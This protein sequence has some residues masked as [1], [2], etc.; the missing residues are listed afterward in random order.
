MAA[1]A[2]KPATVS[3][4]KTTSVQAGEATAMPTAE[5]APVPGAETA[6]VAAAEAP[7]VPGAGPARAGSVPAPGKPG[8]GILEASPDT[9]TIPYRW[10]F[11]V[12]EKNPS[13]YDLSEPIQFLSLLEK[14]DITLVNLTA[15]SPYYNPH[16]QRPAAFPHSD[17]YEA[18][19]DP[20]IGVARINAAMWLRQRTLRLA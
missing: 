17:G 10:G 13:T 8:P 1:P 19:E 5:V 11:G 6:I 14:L 9:Q 12:D 2:A 7:S 15:G 16:I 4:A 18:P 20:L 3:T